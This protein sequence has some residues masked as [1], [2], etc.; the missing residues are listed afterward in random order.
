VVPD[1]GELTASDAVA[2][3]AVGGNSGKTTDTEA[4]VKRVRKEQDKSRNYGK[5]E[6]RDMQRKRTA[7]RLKTTGK[8]LR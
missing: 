8:R 3:E 2:R 4:R 6:V 5:P 1:N 7:I